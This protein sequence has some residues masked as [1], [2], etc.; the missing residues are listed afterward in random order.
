MSVHRGVA[1][2]PRQTLVA[3][4]HDVLARLRVP[5]PF[6]QS[7]VD[8]IDKTGLFAETDQEVVRL[9][10]A[11]EVASGLDVLDAGNLPVIVVRVRDT[12]WSAIMREDLRVN[13]RPQ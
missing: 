12:I 2:G 5:I 4:V 13:L 7:E 10:V 3:P 6:R 11:M 9:D 8:G 1:G